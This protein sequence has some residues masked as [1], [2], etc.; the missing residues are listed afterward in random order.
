MRRLTHDLRP[1]YLDELGLV[2][3]LNMLVATRAKP[4]FTEGMVQLTVQDNG[5]GFV[6]PENPT[7]R[8]ANGHFGLLGIQERAELIGAQMQL[9]STP[10][11]KG[12]IGYNVSD[13]ARG[14]D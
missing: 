14:R 2:P 11:N 4:C 5:Q 3:A 7:T 8:A 9:H 13:D 1:S 10:G 6:V 12:N